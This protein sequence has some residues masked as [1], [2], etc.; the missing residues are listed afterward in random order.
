MSRVFADRVAFMSDFMQR[1][2][3]G[4]SSGEIA[5]RTGIPK[6]SIWQVLNALRKAGIADCTHPAGGV[7]WSRWCPVSEVDRVRALID[8]ERNADPKAVRMREK[9]RLRYHRLKASIAVT[10]SDEP[11]RIIRPAAEC[12]P[13]RPAGPRSVFEIV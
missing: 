2:P 1:H 13:L 12:N 4:L 6:N 7:P 10:E 11:V 9:F 8:A 3:D 5:K